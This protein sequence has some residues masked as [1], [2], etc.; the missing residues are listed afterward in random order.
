MIRRCAYCDS[1]FD[2]RERRCPKGHT[3]AAQAELMAKRIRFSMGLDGE[4]DAE[5]IPRLGTENV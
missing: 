4:P 3:L 5:G 1:L 2:T